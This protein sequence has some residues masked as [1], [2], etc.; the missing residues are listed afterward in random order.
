MQLLVVAGTDVSGR[1]K[2]TYEGAVINLVK[3]LSRVIQLQIP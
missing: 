2:D 3:L 1:I